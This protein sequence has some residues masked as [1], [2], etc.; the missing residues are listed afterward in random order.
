[1]YLLLGLSAFLALGF[2]AGLVLCEVWAIILG[3]KHDSR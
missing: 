3:D 1:M 2:L